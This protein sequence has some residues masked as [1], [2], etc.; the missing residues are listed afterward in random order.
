MA[1][2]QVE[3]AVA[4]NFQGRCPLRGRV[5]VLGVTKGLGIAETVEVAVG[6]GFFSPAAPQ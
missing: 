3:V 6:A 1:G 2:G 5:V 4:I